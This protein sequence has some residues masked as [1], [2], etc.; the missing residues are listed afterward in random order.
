MTAASTRSP[1]SARWARPR[2]I[3]PL[4]LSPSFSGRVKIAGQRF[5]RG[6][7]SISQSV[8]LLRPTPK[9]A[10]RIPALPEKEGVEGRRRL[11]GLLVPL[12]LTACGAEPTAVAFHEDNPAA[13]SAWNLVTVSDG[14]LTPGEGVL[15]YELNTPLFSDYALKFRTIWMPEDAAADYRQGSVFDFPVGTVITKTFYYPQGP[16]GA[17]SVAK[18][19][20]DEGPANAIP[21]DGYHLI[22]TRLLIRDPEGWRAL[23]YVWNAEQSEATLQRGG[24]VKR[25]T[26]RGEGGDKAFAYLVPDANQCAGCHASDNT[27]REI[28]PI[29]PKPRNLNRNYEYADGAANQ[30]DRLHE[31]GYLIGAPAPEAA[32]VLPD[33][34]DEAQPVSLRARAYLDVNCAHCHNPAGPA[35]TSGLH[36]NYAAPKDAHLGLC[37][38]PIAAGRGA[39]GRKYGLVP[40]QPHQSIL[41]FRMQSDE[42]DIMM[43]ELGRALVHEKG[44]ALISDWIAEMS[45]APCEPPV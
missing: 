24:A 9:S 43:P 19:P 33:W 20:D 16:D 42:L 7:S 2:L 26:M 5:W 8:A 28:R 11:W 13:L 6:T 40:T 3:G 14:A 41:L 4:H 32:P 29:G 1:P 35:D 30:L 12:L 45:A 23:P 10:P 27:T 25:L 31:A 15:P 22:E 34:E 38:P 39:G 21:L 37:K 18:P 44:A 36:L 17:A